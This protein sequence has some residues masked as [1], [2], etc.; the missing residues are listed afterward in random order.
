MAR[1]DWIIFLDP[2]MQAQSADE[3]AND[4]PFG[5]FFGEN[6]GFDSPTAVGKVGLELQ[7]FILA[8]RGTR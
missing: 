3:V 5:A 8:T 7:Q 2:T 6:D 4:T 1:K